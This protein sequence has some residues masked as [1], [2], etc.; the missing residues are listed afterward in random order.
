MYIVERL[1]VAEARHEV[2]AV[3]RPEG[4]GTAETVRLTVPDCEA[5]GLAEGAVLSEESRDAVLEAAEKL[6]CVQKALSLLSY[7][8][9]SSRRLTEKL[10][11]HFPPEV[12][13]RTVALL[14]ERGYVDDD[15]LA[16]RYAK[17]Y[18][19][20]R[21][22]GPARIRQELFGKGFS[23]DVIARAVEPYAE[24]DHGERI[25]EL[26]ERKFPSA[27][28]SDPV[29]RRKASDF[30]RRSGYGWEEISSYFREGF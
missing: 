7:G 1:K 3:L 28:F 23:A 24:E 16:A 22:Y 20:I 15:R 25:A 9:Y 11:R 2:T 6:A 10:R 19:R 30:L 13:A 26:L 14:K 17:C 27:D 8:D 12:C 18:A 21:C 4:G 5:L 29:V